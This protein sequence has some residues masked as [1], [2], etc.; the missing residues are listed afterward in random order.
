MSLTTAVK[1]AMLDAITITD[2]SLHSGFPGLTGANEISGGTPAYA[3]KTVTYAAASGGTRTTSASINFDVGAGHTIRWVGN[4]NSA[5]FIGYSPNGGTPK[6]FVA[7]PST[8]LI[9][10]TAHGWSDT[11][12]IAFYNGT[13]PTGLT[14]GTRYY[15][16]DATADTFK[17][18]ATSG[19]AAIDITAA[20]STDCV[21]SSI[22]EEAYASNGST[23]T[24]SSA[25]IGLPF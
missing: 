4:W 22:T 6:E 21:V 25:S 14:E 16:R 12:T 24:I 10:C 17:V 8:D 3:R 19:G 15:V 11:Q 23:H 13:V 20:G 9:N 18:A 2:M 7:T 5:T 1:N